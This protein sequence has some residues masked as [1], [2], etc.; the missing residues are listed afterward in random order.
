MAMTQKLP[1]DIL[2]EISKHLPYQDQASLDRA[3]RDL[4]EV[5]TPRLLPNALSDTDW[6]KARRPLDHAITYGK[7]PLMASIFDLMKDTD[8]CTVANWQRRCAERTWDWIRHPDFDVSLSPDIAVLLQMAAATNSDSLAYLMQKADLEGNGMTFDYV[9]PEWHRWVW[10]PASAQKK[11]ESI[12]GRVV[13][14]HD[15]SIFRQYTE[16]DSRHRKLLLWVRRQAMNEVFQKYE[17]EVPVTIVYN[18]NFWTLVTPE[19]FRSLV[20]KKNHQRVTCEGMYAWLSLSRV[21]AVTNR[22][23]LDALRDLGASVEFVGALERLCPTDP[24]LLEAEASEIKKHTLV[25]MASRD[26][27]PDIPD[28]GPM[29]PMSIDELP[30]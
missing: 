30:Y 14:E 25:G 11:T 26:E 23:F 9:F 18:M 3:D 17:F 27:L 28:E 15:V 29:W 13:S 24:S 10:I 19:A 7:I 6:N 5:L 2:Y 20:W 21:C 16:G 4:H 8:R 22:V 12:L 1:F